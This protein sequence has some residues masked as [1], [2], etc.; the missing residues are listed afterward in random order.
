VSTAVDQPKLASLKG[1]VVRVTLSNGEAVTGRVS[2]VTG[3]AILIDSGYY[4][5]IKLESIRSVEV[6]R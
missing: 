4:R 5:L 2:T 1:K 6:I 3:R